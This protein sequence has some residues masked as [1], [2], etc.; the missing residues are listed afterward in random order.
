[1]YEIVCN[2]ANDRQKW[3][4]ILQKAASNCPPDSANGRFF[5]PGRM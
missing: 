2:T 3:I 1:M 4:P 5:D